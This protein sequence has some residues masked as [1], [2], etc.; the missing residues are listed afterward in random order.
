MHIQMQILTLKKS[1]STSLKEMI[2]DQCVCKA[3]YMYT[4]TP[5]IHTHTHGK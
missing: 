4:H 2:Y 5:H 1:Y 3:I